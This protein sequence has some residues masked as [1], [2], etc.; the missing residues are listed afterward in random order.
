MRSHP[1]IW[2]SCTFIF[3]TQYSRLLQDFSFWRSFEI[4]SEIWKTD[5]ESC[6]QHTYLSGNR[7]LSNTRHPALARDQKR[8]GDEEIVLYQRLIWS[9][10]EK[11][12]CKHYSYILPEKDRDCAHPLLASLWSL[13]ALLNVHLTSFAIYQMTCSPVLSVFVWLSQVRSLS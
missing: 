11:L 5:A 9:F 10:R 13:W 8:W 1:C 12:S 7:E 2:I 6:P 4:L 3:S